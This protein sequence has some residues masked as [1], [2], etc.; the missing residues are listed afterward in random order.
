[1]T[2][3][4]DSGPTQITRNNTSSDAANSTSSNDPTTDMKDTENVIDKNGNNTYTSSPIATATAIVFGNSTALVLLPHT[5]GSAP[6]PP[7]T[8]SSSPQ[9]PPPV[10]PRQ[11]PA[12]LPS[13]APLLESRPVEVQDPHHVIGSS[14][15]AVDADADAHADAGFGA[16][17][18]T[19]TAEWLSIS[20]VSPARTD[21]L[22]RC[23]EII[24]ITIAILLLLGV[25]RT[26][27]LSRSFRFRGQYAA[28]E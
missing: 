9:F 13:P 27:L 4:M 3:T 21:G 5:G 20:K 24:V 1:M 10:M 28:I 23:V 2:C 14:P 11:V 12:P 6:I 15:S 16:H 26:L 17:T 19:G 8:P 22:V 7:T 25:Y 18:G